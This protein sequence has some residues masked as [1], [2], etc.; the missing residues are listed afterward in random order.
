MLTVPPIL[1]DG[2]LIRSG[3]TV[4]EQE[5]SARRRVGWRNDDQLRVSRSYAATPEGL[6][7]QHNL[8]DLLRAGA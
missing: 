2:S 1:G 3:P 5:R 6:S 8:R 4:A 7:G